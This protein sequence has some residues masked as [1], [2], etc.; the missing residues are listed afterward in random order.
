M[1]Q[2][3]LALLCLLSVGLAH[4][5]D[6]A[7]ARAG[8]RY[9]FPRDHGS[10]PDF[11]TEWW[12][13]TGNVAD[14]KGERFGFKLTFFRNRMAP[15]GADTPAS[16]LAATQVY[17]SHF[18]VT[19]IDRGAHA[20]FERI[21][22]AALGQGH[23]SETDFDVACQEWH[24]RRLADD[25]FVLS[26]RDG[27]T[28]IELSLAPQRPFTIHGR[29]GVHVKAAVESQ[30]SHYIS[31]TRMETSGTIVWNGIPHAVRGSGWMD[32]EFGSDQL[33]TTESG[34]DWFG[35]QLDNGDDL[36]VYQLR[37]PEGTAK[38][39][40]HGTIVRADGSTAPLLSGSYTIEATRRWRSPH[41][42]GD[43]PIAWRIAIPSE[44]ITL[45]VE[46]T[47]ADQE[48]RNPRSTGFAYWEGA[49]T[50]RGTK[51][52]AAIAGRGYAELVGYARGDM[53]QPAR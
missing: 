14:A 15:P 25:T 47:V 34:W 32:H 49:V 38:P 6:Y 39:D 53:R 31:F 33:A 9:E 45:E 8:Y 51:N 21:G 44:A 12:Y 17:L 30:A 23:A 52:G 46:A 26:A 24:A 1:I 19:A 7:H 16:P 5:G 18:A 29:D 50:V 22:R 35:L 37:T 11:R 20:N 28:A 48:M 27:D 2:P 40:F 41:T 4:G 42:G 10:H 13:F 36:M 43:Y 3:L